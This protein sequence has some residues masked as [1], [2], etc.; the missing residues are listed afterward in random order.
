[1]LLF[2]DREIVN[3][4]RFKRDVGNKV[5]HNNVTV[6][7]PYIKNTEIDIKPN[8]FDQLTKELYKVAKMF[9]HKKCALTYNIT[10]DSKITVEIFPITETA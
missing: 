8:T 9:P 1:M 10:R 6:T 2:A 4:D 5:L 7:A 3:I